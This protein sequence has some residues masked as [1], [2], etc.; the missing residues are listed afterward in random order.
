MN[1]N[2]SFLVKVGVITGVLVTAAALSALAQWTPAPGSPPGGNTP[3]PINVGTIWQDKMGPLGINISGP[4]TA[5][6]LSG[7]NALEVNGNG[8]FNTVGV[9]TDIL[10]GRDI[11]ATRNMTATAFFYS[12]DQTLK[13]DIQTLSPEESLAKIMR[14]NPVSFEWID[15]ARGIG[16]NIGL[17]AQDVEKVFPEV[18]G[19]GQDG[20][21][22]I[23][24]GNLIAPLIS[25]LQQ[26]Q[27]EINAL[28]AEVETLKAQR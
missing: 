6:S 13:K 26:Q 11:T 21:L 16:T 28:K 25:A 19:T 24:Y 14:L 5:G 4:C 10:A 27:K 9:G 7:C 1:K 15:S 2:T 23:G 18:I 8:L 22:T 17:V 20:K 12:S 3:A